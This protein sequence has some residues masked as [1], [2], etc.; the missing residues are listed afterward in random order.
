MNKYHTVWI[1]DIHL[2]TPY[3]KSNKLLDFLNKNSSD[4]LYLVGDVIDAWHM[5]KNWFWN[6]EQE[7]ILNHIMLRA[8]ISQ[9]YLLTGNHDEANVILPLNKFAP[10]EVLESCNYFT[11]K[12]DKYLVAHGHQF[13]SNW[14]RTTSDL[15]FSV[16]I[17]INDWYFNAGFIKRIL[18]S[19]ITNI[20][21]TREKTLYKKV[22]K[23]LTTDYKGIICGH[24][25]KPK[26][27]IIDNKYTYYNT[28][29][30]VSHCT[31]VIEDHEGNLEL[32]T[33]AN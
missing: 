1:S 21:S 9:V 3:C 8:Q 30:W 17:L 29:D 20:T 7:E 31:Y 5:G 16:S 13:D 25:H 4:N 28:G 26:M 33:Y 18:A 12:G 14:L 15:H 27:D 10:L 24:L 22:A 6:E 19:I 23:S 11:L 2:G 32:K